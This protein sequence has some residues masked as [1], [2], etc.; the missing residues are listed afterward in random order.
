MKSK[1]KILIVYASFG[2]GHIQVTRALK[3]S[4]LQRGGTDVATV[5]LL[6]EA[7]PWINAIT[8]S[9]YTKSS[10]F[11]PALYG[12]SYRYTEHLQHDQL[13]VKWMNSLCNRKLNEIVLAEQ[14][15][16]IV[17]TFPMLSLLEL[18]KKKG[19]S[20]PAVTVL[21][22]YVLHQ[23]WVHPDTDQYY[24]AT[25]DLQAELAAQ[26]IPKERVQVSGIPIRNAFNRSMDA[27]EITRRYGFDPSRK[28][29][30]IMAGAYGVLSGI[31]EIIHRLMLVDDVQVAL[32]CGKNEALLH[33]MRIS[34]GDEPRVTL[35]GFVEH[36]EELMKV[37]S[38]M[39][40]KAGGVT[41]SEALAMDLPFIVYRP[42][43]G[44]E[45]GNA[46]YLADCGSG[47]IAEKVE[48]IRQQLE[49]ILAVPPSGA[50]RAGRPQDGRPDAAATIVSGVLKLMDRPA[51]SQPQL[52]PLKPKR[53]KAL[54]G[55]LN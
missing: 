50:E 26:G 28:I 3:E 15:D 24:V 22:D 10:R 35:F 46:R 40:T 45:L 13:L 25:G 6:A 32:V 20:I 11:S 41:L 27:M 23:R 31:D 52:I 5:D 4:F 12:W 9:M 54:H 18:R 55:N 7:H 33:K 42:L 1:K 48:D 39:V 17:H 47:T 34:F 19:W 30:L 14:P 53:R 51:V 43:P 37:A 36:V 29:V 8:R 44:Q 16:V 49:Q 2:D 21:T 38:C